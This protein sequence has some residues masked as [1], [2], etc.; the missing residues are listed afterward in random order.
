MSSK[1][2]KI[3]SAAGT[4]LTAVQQLGGNLRGLVAVNTNAAI[5]FIKFYDVTDQITVGTTVPVLTVQL[6]A[7]SM[8]SIFPSDG[9]N[10]KLGISLAMT[11][12]A[13]DSAS[14]A[15]GAGD[16]IATVLYE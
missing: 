13:A 15:V 9:I 5:R 6:A 11:V 10:F 14:D 2:L 1:K 7:S 4:N 3:T 16:V 12:S 8:T